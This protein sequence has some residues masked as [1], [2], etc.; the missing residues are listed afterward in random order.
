MQNSRQISR[1][2]ILCLCLLAALLDDAAAQSGRKQKKAEPQPPVQGTNQPDKRVQNNDFGDA[3]TSSST[4]PEP[5]EKNGQK[6]LEALKKHLIVMSSMPDM[7]VSLYFA[8]IARQGCSNELRRI[9]TT[10]QVSEQSNQNR[11]DALKAAKEADDTYV[12]LL[13][14]ES[15]SGMGA[16]NGMDLRFT[17]FEPKTGKQMAFGNGYPNPPSR[18]GAQM[19]P[20]GA[21]NTALRMDWAARDVAYQIVSKLKLR[22]GF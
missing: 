22:P 16:I 3:A 20:M 6:K 8:D 1:W 9:V 17:L 13:E 10:L 11:S 7:N 4:D 12:V 19:P 18:G 15:M 2:F 14:I 5:E 21:N